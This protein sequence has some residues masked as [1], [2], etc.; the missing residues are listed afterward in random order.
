MPRIL[1]VDN[2]VFID[3]RLGLAGTERVKA[4]AIFGDAGLP[5]HD[6]V[7]ETSVID[8]IGL[9]LDGSSCLLALVL[10]GVGVSAVL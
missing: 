7:R 1:S 9:E 8:C 2:Q 3:R 6:L 10:V 4:P 5:H